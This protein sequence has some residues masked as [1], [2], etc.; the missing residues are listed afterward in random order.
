MSYK[1]D[2]NHSCVYTDTSSGNTGCPGSYWANPINK[3]CTTLCPDGY[4]ADQALHLCVA[5]CPSYYYAD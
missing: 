3:M 2:V 1:Y 4:F 5:I